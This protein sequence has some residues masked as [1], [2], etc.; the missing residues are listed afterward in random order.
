MVATATS[1]V[2]GYRQYLHSVGRPL[3]PSVSYR[4]VVIFHTEPVIIILV[5]KL[6]PVAT[7]LTRSIS[8]CHIAEVIS[9]LRFTCSTHAPREERISAVGGGTPYLFGVNVLA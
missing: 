3:T 2:A 7:S 9:I 6:V 1:L 4:M 8:S 5:Q